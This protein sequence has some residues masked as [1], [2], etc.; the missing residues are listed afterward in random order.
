MGQIVSV[1][2]CSHAPQIVTRPKIDEDYYNKVRKVQ[3]SI[4][5]L[6]DLLKER[7][8][9]VM[10]LIGA[11]HLESFFFDNYPMLLLPVVDKAKGEMA[12]FSAEYTVNKGVAEK[13]LFSLINQ[14][15]DVSFSQNFRLDHQYLSPLKW[16]GERFKCPIVPIHINSNVPPLMLPKRAL[17]LGRAIRKAIINE[18]DENLKVAVIGTGG[19]SHFPGTPLYGKVDIEFD[20]MILDKIETAKGHEL[21]SLSPSQLENSGN[22]E[23]RTWLCAMGSS[24]SGKGNIILHMPTFHI[25]YAVVDF[26]L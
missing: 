11:D 9:D 16:I 5:H 14:G 18:T 3:E 7:S 1:L 4:M 6:G 20:N 12:G 2:A 23:L 25:D 26:D 10:L 22:L 21:A 17:S 24:L 13:L 15:F 19:L 8:P